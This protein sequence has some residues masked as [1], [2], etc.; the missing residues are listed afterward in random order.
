M[1]SYVTGGQ[2]SGQ[3]RQAPVPGLVIVTLRTS[4]GGQPQ[5]PNQ[6]GSQLVRPSLSISQHTV[7]LASQP[8]SH[9]QRELHGLQPSLPQPS[10]TGLHRSPACHSLT[11]FSGGNCDKVR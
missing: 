8:R 5:C 11:G 1:L 7:L 2:K 10:E 6:R 9:A 3:A 4:S